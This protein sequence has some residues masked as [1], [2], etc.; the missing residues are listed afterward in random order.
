MQNCTVEGFLSSN[1]SAE[2]RERRWQECAQVSLNPVIKR[3]DVNILH[4]HHLR[5]ESLLPKYQHKHKHEL[6]HVPQHPLE[7]THL[8][9]IVT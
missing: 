1:E 8:G 6:V 4:R 5:T 3:W 9:F 2:R 7:H